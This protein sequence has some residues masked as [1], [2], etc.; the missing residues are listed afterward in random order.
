MTHFCQTQK[1]DIF[2]ECSYV[3]RTAVRHIL[4]FKNIS[5]FLSW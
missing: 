3:A 2:I 5:S 1:I 4:Y